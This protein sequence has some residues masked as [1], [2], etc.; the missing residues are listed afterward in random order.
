MN[1]YRK[2]FRDVSGK[3]YW[4]IPRVAGWLAFAGI[5][6]AGVYLVAQ[7]GKIAQRTFNADNMI[8][9]Y[10]FFRDANTQF[11]ARKGQIATHKAIMRDTTTDRDRL[12]IEL[13]SMQQ[14]CRE[15]AAKYNANASKV[16]RNLFMGSGVPE[17]L[18]MEGCE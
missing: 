8:A 7:P 1:D 13:A 18:P 9:N 5:F 3:V 12:R 10:E 16:N 11:A 6:S 14:S 2:D 17:T 4:T 15:I